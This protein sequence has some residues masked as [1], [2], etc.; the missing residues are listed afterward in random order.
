M[1][2]KLDVVFQQRDQSNTKFVER[3]ISGS[4]LIIQTN[5]SGTLIGQPMDKH[6]SGSVISA[7]GLYVSGF[8]N[9]NHDNDAPQFIVGNMA[10]NTG[11]FDRLYLNPNG[12]APAPISSTS[13]GTEGELRTDDNFLYLYLNGKWR[14][15]PFS[16]F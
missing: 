2:K 7:S 1:P 14:R 11:S 12:F 13:Y 8:V 4:N 10:V 16:L 9:L 5:K 15:S 6:F 3:V